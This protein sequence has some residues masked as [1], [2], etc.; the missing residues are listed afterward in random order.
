MSR[1]LLDKNITDNVYKLYHSLFMGFVMGV[2]E[3]ILMVGVVNMSIADAVL[4][5]GLSAATIVVVL[6]ARRGVGIDDAQFLNAM[7]E[8]HEMAIVMARKISEKSKR[9]DVQKLASQIITAQTDEIEQM[10]KMLTLI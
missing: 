3:I 2:L 1:V 9:P 10:K 6:L 5:G 7:I 4:L 8:H